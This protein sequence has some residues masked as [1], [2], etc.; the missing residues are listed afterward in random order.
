MEL[1]Q[2]ARSVYA[3]TQLGRPTVLGWSNS[4]L[5]D[6]GN[7]LVVDT[8]WDRP[9]TEQLLG[10]YAGVRPQRPGTL[11]NTHHNV[12]HT[13]GNAV[14]RGARII[15]HAN[16]GRAMKAEAG[17]QGLF[18][19]LVDADPD[20]LE[21]AQ[22]ALAEELRPFDHASHE[23]ELPTETVSETTELDLGE[24]LVRLI[25][26]GP[27]HTDNDIVVHL[28]EQ[29]VLFTGDLLFNQC[30][31]IGWAG[32][33]RNWMDA[34]DAMVALEPETV[35]PGHGPVCGTEALAGLR[36]YF[37]YVLAEARSFFDRGVAVD[38]ACRQI[39]LGPYGA[40]EA[41]E[42]LVF[43]VQRAYNEFA[44]ETAAPVDAADMMSRA[45]ALRL[46][47]QSSPMEEQL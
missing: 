43:N 36:D 32:T 13:G 25:P 38:D 10:L 37:A 42:R 19:A 4:G 41:P 27:A 18:Q 39:D 22:A 33:T 45:F 16:C 47:M 44:G 1:K 31:P 40:W 24:T 20:G 46:D 26:L 9:L 34:L 12:D 7:G 35:V 15:A 11:V 29:N 5:V 30:T 14:L 3:C 23:L 8:F 28:P 17:M 6:A 21:P 2:I